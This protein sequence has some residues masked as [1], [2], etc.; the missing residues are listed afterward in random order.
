MVSPGPRSRTRAD[1]CPGALSVHQ[2]ADG[3]LARLRAPGGLLTPEQ[4]QLLGTAAAELGD[5]A[6]ELTS[7][8][9]VQLRAVTDPDEL[10]RRLVAGG[11]LPSLTHERVRNYL[12]SPLTGRVGGVVDVRGWVGELDRRLCADERLAGLP[13]RFLT[14]FDDGRGDVSPLAADVGI[15]VVDAARVAV[16]VAGRDH[17]IRVGHDRAVDAVLAA[18]HLFLDLR[19]NQW[20]IAELAG[21]GAELATALAAQLAVRL[22]DP[23]TDQIAGRIELRTDGRPPIGWFDHDCAV[24]PGAAT[25]GAVTLGAA[26]PLGR[27]SAR[28]CE[29]LAATERPIV[30]TPWRT[31]LICDLDDWSAEQVVRVLAPMGLVFDENSPWTRVSAC[32]G[33]PGCAKALADVRVDA[34]A[35]VSTRLL[36]DGAPLGDGELVHFAGCERRCG[37]P[38]GEVTDVVATGSAYRVDRDPA[39]SDPT[40][41]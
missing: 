17:G 4:V 22:G 20:R 41:P 2:A 3:A 29:F 39:P 26:V 31:L 14:S 10:A 19:S 12:V 33:R 40:E 5:G 32:A 9:N 7:R 24:A 8:G 11:L 6:V 15:H 35:A 28:L 18:A 25:P 30:V 37:R 13:G 23:G 34:S 21:G 38:R 1:A 16:L 27:V 36:P